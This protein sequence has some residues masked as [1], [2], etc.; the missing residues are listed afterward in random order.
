MAAL[1][2]RM[3]TAVQHRSVIR[4]PQLAQGSADCQLVQWRWLCEL[5][6]MNQLSFNEVSTSNT[7]ETPC[8]R[9]HVFNMTVHIEQF[10]L[11]ESVW[12]D[13]CCSCPTRQISLHISH[14]KMLFIDL[15]KQFNNIKLIWKLINTVRLELIWK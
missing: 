13:R 1:R 10:S 11:W 15:I 9:K 6:T 14:P 5:A 8:N 4:C 3:C 7:V 2:W 12:Y